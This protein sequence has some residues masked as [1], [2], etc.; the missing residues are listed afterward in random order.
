MAEVELI[1]SQPATPTEKTVAAIDALLKRAASAQLQAYEHIRTLVYANPSK[2]TPEQVYAAF[3]GTTT[4]GMTS[5]QL[6]EAA[7]IAKASLNHFQAVIDDAVPA[8]NI[9]LE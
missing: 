2:L 5:A 3:E 1:E 9:T 7:R 6:G 4:T 8:A